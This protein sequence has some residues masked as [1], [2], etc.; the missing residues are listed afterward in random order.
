MAPSETP[1][2]WVLPEG[3]STQVYLAPLPLAL[4]AWPAK[5]GCPNPAGLVDF[6]FG[7]PVETVVYMWDEVR[8]GDLHRQRQVTDP[9]LWPLLSAAAAAGEPTTPDWVREPMPAGD[10]PYADLIAAQCGREILELT[11]LVEVCPGPCLPGGSESLISQ[12]LM[13]RRGA[14]WLIWAVN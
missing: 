10:S 2:L 14:H 1:T 5:A 11:W 12:V 3:F 7:M 8:S 6:E 13:I 4:G 9:A